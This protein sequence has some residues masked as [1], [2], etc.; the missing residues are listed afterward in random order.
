MR[1]LLIAVAVL[2]AAPASASACSCALPQKP[3]Q[4]IRAA[5]AAVFVKVVKRTVAGSEGPYIT[6]EKLRYRLRV[7]RDFKRNVPGRITVTGS[8]N[9]ALCGL[10]LRRGQ[11]VG[12]L[13]DKARRGYSGSLCG[14]RTLEHLEAGATKKRAQAS[15]SGCN[16]V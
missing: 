2:L 6:G 11:K 3:R 1:V 15:A 5:D 4:E 16:A 8:S 7:I 12:L 9:S 10:S 13:L 14:V